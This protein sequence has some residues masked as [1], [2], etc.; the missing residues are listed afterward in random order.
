ML[1]Y[2]QPEIDRK[3]TIF[4]LHQ[5]KKILIKK[6]ESVEAN[7]WAKSLVHFFS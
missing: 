6:R 3:I 4:S 5:K 7:T 1:E 2:F